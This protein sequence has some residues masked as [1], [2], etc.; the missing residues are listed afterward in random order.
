M[1]M[2]FG[3]KRATATKLMRQLTGCE[4]N[5][6]DV[7]KIDLNKLTGQ[8]YTLMITEEV[9]DSGEPVNKIASIK[10]IDGAI[11]LTLIQA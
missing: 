1:G 5:N 4:L 3:A 7:K 6:D 10:R 2:S 9:N 11:D 8:E